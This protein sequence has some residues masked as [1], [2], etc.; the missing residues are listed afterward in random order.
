MQADDFGP[1]GTS[2][3]PSTGQGAKA[4]LLAAGSAALWQIDPALVELGELACSVAAAGTQGMARE[5]RPCNCV[6]APL[7]CKNAWPPWARVRWTVWCAGLN[8]PA[9]ACWTSGH[10]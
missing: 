4:W 5:S 1:E 8:A 10:G 3:T 6:S 2:S 7:P 9:A